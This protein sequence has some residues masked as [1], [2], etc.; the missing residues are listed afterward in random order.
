MSYVIANI[1][2]SCPYIGKSSMIPV[3][4]IDY[5][6]FVTCMSRKSEKPN[7]FGYLREGE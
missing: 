5:G 3:V 6:P 7:D 2:Y 4:Y 1:A